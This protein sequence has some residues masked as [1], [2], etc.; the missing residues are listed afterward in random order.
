MLSKEQL[1]NFSGS[2]NL[3]FD[4]ILLVLNKDVKNKNLLR[5]EKKLKLFQFFRTILPRW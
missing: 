1:T 3:V 4:R 5:F 2:W